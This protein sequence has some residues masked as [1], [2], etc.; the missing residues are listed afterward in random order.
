[1]TLAVVNHYMHMNTLNVLVSSKA[2]TLRKIKLLSSVRPSV[3]AS[4]RACVHACVRVCVPPS[5]RPTVRASVRACVRASV[6]A[7]VRACVR[8]SVRHIF[9]LITCS[10]IYF[11]LFII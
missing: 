6:C 4:V 10:Y 8:P 11:I 2:L 1:M 9:G 7:S 3:R 5:V